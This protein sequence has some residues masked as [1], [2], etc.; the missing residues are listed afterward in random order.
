MAEKDK[1]PKSGG[2]KD[3]VAT[4][5]SLEAESTK[6]EKA[7]DSGAL[8]SSDRSASDKADAKVTAGS[9]DQGFIKRITHNLNPYMILMVVIVISGILI[10]FVANR[11]N[12]QDDPA[13]LVIEGHDLDQEAIDQLIS[14]ES[15]VGTID[16][17]L[18]VAANAIFEGKILVKGSLDVAGSIN[19]GGPLS[20]PGITV[21][22]ESE[23][24]DVNVTN[25]LSILGSVSVQ[26]T[27]TVQGALN[28]NNDL[29]VAGTISA[30]EISADKVEFTG[31]LQ[32][33]RHIDTGGG[34]PAITR[35]GSVGAGGTVSIS[36]NDVS[37]TVTIN[38]GGSP[39]S[40]ILASITFRS[41]Y[42]TTPNV[43]ITPANAASGGLNYYVT[44]SSTTF[45]VGNSGAPAASTTYMFDYFI[46]E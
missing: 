35:G 22:G 32:L 17:T 31:D 19:V 9:T 27:L 4:D 18:T 16:Q 41:A 15:N 24:E 20:L 37:G 6:T 46:V 8:E 5:S 44:R 12:N 36:G 28:V 40:G 42:N 29:S 1:K 10:I 39:S 14:G 34:T 38:T 43:Q 33:T 2:S 30:N 25:N 45:N 13:T 3:E 21:S 11:V 7:D 23:F 26:G